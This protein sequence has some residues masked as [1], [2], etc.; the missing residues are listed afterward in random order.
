MFVA[1]ELLLHDQHFGGGGL[2]VLWDVPEV[3]V[4]LLGRVVHEEW[5]R[6]Q[7]LEGALEDVC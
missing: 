1:V 5:T 6:Y 7:L 2:R 3:G 4:E